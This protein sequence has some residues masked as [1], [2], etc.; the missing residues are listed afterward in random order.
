MSASEI[1][2][3]PI[4]VTSKLHVN[5]NGK[6]PLDADE[7]VNVDTE[8]TLV[9]PS[10]TVHFPGDLKMSLDEKAPVVQHPYSMA[11]SMV[12]VPCAAYA[13]ELFLASH[14]LE[15]EEYI[16]KGDPQKCVYFN[17]CTRRSLMSETEN[18]STSLLDMA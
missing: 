18:V 11:H 15:S 12:D 14:M 17:P 16:H 4:D 8:D 1:D 9:T 5:S 10:E 2:T 7:S 6:L 3:V 13:L